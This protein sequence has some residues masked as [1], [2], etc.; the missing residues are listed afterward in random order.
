MSR[1]GCGGALGAE[2]SERWGSEALQRAGHGDG[3]VAAA[4]LGR[5][6]VARGG[7][8]Q[9]EGEWVQ[10]VVGVPRGAVGE[11]GGGLRPS[12]A[13]GSAAQRR[14]AEKQRGREEEEGGWTGFQILESS[15]V[16]L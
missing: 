11:A 5:D 1:I 14:R 2:A 13:A 6:G 9:H 4:E 10:E 3:E 7:G 16:P 8:V 15:R 12:S